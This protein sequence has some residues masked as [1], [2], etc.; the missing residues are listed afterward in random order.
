[1]FS[2][3]SP[4]LFESFSSSKQLKLVNSCLRNAALVGSRKSNEN[5]AE[6]DISALWE[7]LRKMLLGWKI[8]SALFSAI[9]D[10]NSKFLEDSLE[11]GSK[12]LR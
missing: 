12:R 2:L 9:L 7:V 10:E 3:I 4:S 5:A 1:M 8:D 11:Q 6:I